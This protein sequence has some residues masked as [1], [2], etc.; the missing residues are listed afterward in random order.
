MSLV[1]LLYARLT[2]FFFLLVDWS[3]VPLYWG[4][5]FKW[6]PGNAKEKGDLSYCLSK[7]SVPCLFIVCPKN[8][9]YTWRLRMWSWIVLF[10][11]PVTEDIYLLILHS[12]T[13]FMLQIHGSRVPIHVVSLN[14]NSP[15]TITFLKDVS[16]IT[17]GRYV[18]Y[19][20]VFQSIFFFQ[21]F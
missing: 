11:Q 20:D 17:K 3:S 2:V 5:C 15:A 14:C 1:C 21:M 16:G 13:I 18:F 7:Y 6:I 9:S 10:G 19:S 4:R 8:V 12:M